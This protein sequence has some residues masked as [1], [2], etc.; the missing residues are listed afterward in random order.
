MLWI[1]QLR[2]KAFGQTSRGRIPGFRGVDGPQHSHSLLDAAIGLGFKYPS[3]SPVQSLISVHM[4]RAV[5]T[6]EGLSAREN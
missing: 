5:T 1:L 4:G 3:F 6:E 2:K